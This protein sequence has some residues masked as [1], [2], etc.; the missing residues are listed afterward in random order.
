MAAN[1]LPGNCGPPTRPR[2][3]P[4][5][6]GMARAW[7][8]ADAQD[9]LRGHARR[10]GD[11]TQ[12]RALAEH[13]GAAG[14]VVDGCHPV[15]KHARHVVARVGRYQR[16]RQAAHAQRRQC[17]DCTVERADVADALL[18][19]AAHAGGD[20]RK[21]PQRHADVGDQFASAHAAIVVQ[22]REVQRREPMT[23]SGKVDVGQEPGER[24]RQGAVEIEDDQS[25]THAGRV[26][27][28]LAPRSTCVN[29]TAIPRPTWAVR[30]GNP[31]PEPC[32]TAPDTRR[33]Q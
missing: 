6:C 18:H 19:R 4:R 20:R 23:R 26:L 24:V 8:A 32:R 10:P 21:L 28:P 27:A 33:P 11:T 17:F 14:E 9:L 15:A 2:G 22:A 16:S 25:V 13:A 7:S 30:V 5:R 1:G 3:S 29:R 31:P 12:Q